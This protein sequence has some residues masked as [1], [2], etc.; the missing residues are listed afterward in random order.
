MAGFGGFGEDFGDAVE[1]FA[2]RPLETVGELVEG[3]GFDADEV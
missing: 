3:V 1:D 2:L